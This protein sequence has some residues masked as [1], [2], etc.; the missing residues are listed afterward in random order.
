MQGDAWMCHVQTQPSTC[1]DP[2]NKTGKA[3]EASAVLALQLYAVGQHST[4]IHKAAA[5]PLPLSRD[6]KD[7]D[8]HSRPPNT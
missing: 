6:T 7:F 1:P 2:S 4:P 3:P 8:E 5:T